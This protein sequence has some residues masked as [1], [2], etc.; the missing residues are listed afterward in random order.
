MASGLE[1]IDFLYQLEWLRYRKQG[2]LTDLDV[3]FS[4]DQSEKL[5]VQHRL[6]QKSAAVFAW[7][8]RGA[9]IYVCGDAEHMAGDVH[10][11]LLAIVKQEGGLSEER[12]EDYVKDLKQARRYQ[13]DVY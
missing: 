8:Q 12:A 7:L 3:A 11:A 2:L 4:R 10:N 13:R 9:H 5:Y 6:L 1:A